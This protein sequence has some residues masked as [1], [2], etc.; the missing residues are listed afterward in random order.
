MH[1]IIRDTSNIFKRSTHHTVVESSPLICVLLE[2]LAD[3][4]KRRQIF[5]TTNFIP[6]L[7]QQPGH[8]ITVW[9]FKSDSASQQETPF[10]FVYFLIVFQNIHT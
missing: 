1:C 10:I 4:S 2:S 7:I 3:V 8:G 9:V 5:K 6:G